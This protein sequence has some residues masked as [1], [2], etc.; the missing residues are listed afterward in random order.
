MEKFLVGF[1]G[2][3]AA[4]TPNP[5]MSDEDLCHLFAQV[6]HEGIESGHKTCST[7]KD[8][9]DLEIS[10]KYRKEGGSEYT[11]LLEIKK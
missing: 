2:V 4:V 9:K 5:N 10:Y 3:T 11:Y 1:T 7:L 8:I 6:V